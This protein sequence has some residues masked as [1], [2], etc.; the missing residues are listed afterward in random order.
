MVG[1]SS[2]NRQLPKPHAS[3]RR[4]L[5]QVNITVRPLAQELQMPITGFPWNTLG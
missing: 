3:P 4:Q 1:N 2:E 5:P